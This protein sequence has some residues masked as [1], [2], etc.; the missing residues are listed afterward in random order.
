MLKFTPVVGQPVATH[1]SGSFGEGTYST[2]YVVVKVTP[3]GQV[4]I[5]RTTETSSPNFPNVDRRFDTNGYE[6]GKG[7]SRGTR[8]VSVEEATQAIELRAK[9]NAIQTAFGQ[10]QKTINEYRNVTMGDYETYLKAVES[11]EADVAQAR[12]VVEA[13]KVAI[14]NR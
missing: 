12:Q 1:R 2:G 8:L 10:I 9:R 14:L 13:M 4:I 11:I 6:M 3:S 5:R 7:Y